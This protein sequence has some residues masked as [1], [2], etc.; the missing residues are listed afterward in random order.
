MQQSLEAIQ[1]LE[2]ENNQLKKDKQEF[3]TELDILRS[4][5]KHLQTI[6]ETSLEDKKRLTDRINNFTII[7]HDLNM[8]I[9]R[10]TQLLAE[11]RKKIAE[12]EVSGVLKSQQK[13]V[14][15]TDSVF[16]RICIFFFGKFTFFESFF[17]FSKNI[18]KNRLLKNYAIGFI[19][20]YM[21]NFQ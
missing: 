12:L 6:L 15:P 5:K 2:R 7:E 8:E 16:V 1:N 3:I 20:V 11:Q 10:L 4:E 21:L 18:D 14:S 9:D 17:V 13:E 19:Y